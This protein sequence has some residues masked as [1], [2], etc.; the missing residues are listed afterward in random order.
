MARYV[1]HVRGDGPEALRGAV[2]LREHFAWF[3]LAF[4]PFWFLAKGAWIVALLTAAGMLVTG[5]AIALVGLP[6][7]FGFAVQLLIGVFLALEAHALHSWELQLK[8]YQ[9]VA[10]VAGDDREE[11]ERRFFA[12]ALARM[13]PP[14]RSHAGGLPQRSGAVPVIGLFPSRDGSAG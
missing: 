11:V 6:P 5:W 1:V 8:G 13:A 4:G 7:V 14:S 12:D 10:V 2:F 9:D 3:A